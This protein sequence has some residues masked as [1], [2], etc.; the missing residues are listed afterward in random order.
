MYSSPIPALALFMS[1]AIHSSLCIMHHIAYLLM[2]HAVERTRSVVW[3]AQHFVWGLGEGG[4]VCSLPS[5]CKGKSNRNSLF[6]KHLRAIDLQTN[7]FQ[8]PIFP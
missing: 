2:E 6:Y 4:G 3:K 5:I 1:L 7:N 8:F